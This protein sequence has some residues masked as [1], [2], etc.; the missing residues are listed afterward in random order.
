MKLYEYVNEAALVGDTNLAGFIAQH[1]MSPELCSAAV[2]GDATEAEILTLAN[3][4]RPE[5]N[6]V[7]LAPGGARSRSHQVLSRLG[8]A[9]L[10]SRVQVADLPLP[11]RWPKLLSALSMTNPGL[12][13]VS[14]QWLQSEPGFWSALAS[15]ADPKGVV[16]CVRCLLDYESAAASIAAIRTIP[17]DSDVA[18]IAASPRS[19]WLA[20]TSSAEALRRLLASSGLFSTPEGTR[21]D[22]A[23]AVIAYDR[24]LESLVTEDGRIPRLVRYA[25]EVSGPGLE[26]SGGWAGP[27]DD[28]R[29]TDSSQAS[30]Q[31]TLPKD[32]TPQTLR[33]VAN[34]WIPPD[35]GFQ[36][37]ELGVGRSPKTWAREEFKT[38]S[39]V[40]PVDLEL[41]EPLASGKIALQVKVAKAGRP[42]DHGGQDTRMLGLK[43]RTLGVYT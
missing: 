1:W 42:S 12:L 6:L 13:S 15:V 32:V 37:V 31:L 27:E 7:V 8:E 5:G 38:D 14:A 17:L 26:F 40:R 25:N 41:G 20:S 21:A 36:E 4:L 24:R 10:E 30:L 28:G 43:L 16:V 19:V 18:V 9:G 11:G 34:A 22:G 29:W 39:E 35:A 33:V 3:L 23:S 2:L